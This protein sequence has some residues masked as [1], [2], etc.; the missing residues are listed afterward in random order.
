MIP[1]TFEW[2]SCHITV[3][4]QNEDVPC[5]LIT[6]DPFINVRERHLSAYAI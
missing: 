5:T 1:P 6:A 2:V 3:D 4:I